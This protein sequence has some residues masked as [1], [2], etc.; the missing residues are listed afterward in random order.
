MADTFDSLS[1]HPS[2]LKAIKQQGYST[3]TP[4]QKQAIP[5]LLEGRDVLGCAQTGTGKTAAFSLPIL[6]HLA[7]KKSK[8]KRAIRGLILSPTRE[9]AAQ[10]AENI[11]HY[12]RHLDIRHLCI[13]EIMMHA[14][15]IILE[16]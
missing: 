13:F 10:I 11:G 7:K 14:R 2:L 9:L 3:P 16:S 15:S 4:I 8:G 6:H 5:S 12:S 1:L